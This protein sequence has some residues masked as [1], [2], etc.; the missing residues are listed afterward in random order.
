MTV[1][2]QQDVWLL[3]HDGAR[4]WETARVLDP[5]LDLDGLRREHLHHIATEAFD[6]LVQHLPV[7]RVV[8][9]E[10]IEADGA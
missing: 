2:A 8:G 5:R 6:E 1:V 7:S 9:R 10:V 3:L 4:L